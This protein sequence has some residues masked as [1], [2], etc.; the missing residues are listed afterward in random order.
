M[1]LELLDRVVGYGRLFLIEEVVTDQTS[2]NGSRH[3]GRAPDGDEGLHGGGNRRGIRA[4]AYRPVDV[5]CHDIAP[6]AHLEGEVD[7]GDPHGGVRLS[8]QGLANKLLRQG[9]THGDPRATP[10]PG[11]GGGAGGLINEWDAWEVIGFGVGV[12][13]AD[14]L[15]G[16]WQVDGLVVSHNDRSDHGGRKTGLIMIMVDYLHIPRRAVK[17][18]HCPVDQ[19][20]QGRQHP[21]HYL[22]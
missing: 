1:I 8:V 11:I 12:S 7:A 20:H 19:G 16:A 3:C 5:L 2:A 21:R 9:L 17:Y 10:D 4:I 14:D 6:E 13:D 22:C 18:S 15:L